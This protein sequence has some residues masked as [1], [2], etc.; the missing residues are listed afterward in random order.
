[1]ISPVLII[2]VIGWAV[3]QVMKLLITSAVCRKFDLRY[4]TASGGMPS[5]HSSL[6]C[7]CATAT[8]FA[9]GPGSTV[10]AVAVVMAFI[11]MHDAANVRKETGE[12][13]KILNY[14]MQNWPKDRPVQFE[15]DLKELIGHTPLQVTIG[16]ILGI[17]I[18]VVG[19][20]IA[21]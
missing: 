11:V 10:F 16:A 2:A 12:Q 3:A 20:V 6:V 9:A 8:A 19:G 1:M 4:L 21:Y 15:E 7:A 17:I 14:I 5:S 13:A 18:G